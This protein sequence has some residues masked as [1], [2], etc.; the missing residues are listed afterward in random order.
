M[1][2]IALELGIGT[3]MRVVR[4]RTPGKF[5]GRRFQRQPRRAACERGWAGRHTELARDVQRLT[6]HERDIGRGK[7]NPRPRSG[8]ARHPKYRSEINLVSLVQQAKMNAGR[9][10]IL[11]NRICLVRGFSTSVPTCRFPLM[12]QEPWR[13]SIAQHYR[14]RPEAEKSGLREGEGHRP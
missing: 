6:I 8:H 4:S 3:S 2:L 9:I 11:G 5:G 12:T 10:Q 7:A 14:D 13:S 1:Q